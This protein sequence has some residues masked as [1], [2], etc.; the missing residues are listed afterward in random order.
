VKKEPWH[1]AG[2]SGT[3]PPHQ[4]GRPGTVHV[5]LLLVAF[6]ALIPFGAPARGASS[7]DITALVPLLSHPEGWY[8]HDILLE[9]DPGH[10]QAEIL[11]TLDGSTP[12][13]ENGTEYTQPIHLSAR[14]PGVT[15]LRARLASP[16]GELGPTLNASYWLGVQAELPMVSLIADP[17][18]LWGPEGGIHAHPLNRGRAWERPVYV[19]Y[20]E[21]KEVAFQVPAG[22]RIHG[23]STRTISKKSYRLYFRQEYGLNRLDYSLFEG[24]EG[25]GQGDWDSEKR[26]VL[27]DGGQDFAFPGYGANWT[28]IRTPLIND[29][30]HQLQVHSTSSRPVLLF[31]NGVPQGIYHIR[32]YIDDWFFAD[33]YGVDLTVDE[34]AD[35]H[36]E[37]FSEFLATQDVADSDNYLYLQSQ[38]DLSNLIDYYLLQIY[39]ANSDWLYTNV[40]RFLPQTHGGRWQWILW[41]VDYGFGL[42]PWGSYDYNMMDYIFYADRPGLEVEARPLRRLLDNPEFRDQFLGRAADLLNTVFSP[43][44]VV[45]RIDRLAAQLRPD[46]QY[47]LSLW[48]SPGD[49]EASV[50]Y[51]RE[52]ALK[53]PDAVREH[54]VQHFNLGGTAELAFSPPAEGKGRVAVN[55]MM[56]PDEPWQGVYFQGTVVRVTA[57]PEPGYCFA[58]WLPAELPQTPVITLSVS[59]PQTFAPRFQRDCDRQPQPGDVIITQL[60]V[61][62]R[63]AIEGDWLELRVARPGG[64]DLRGWRITDNDTKTSTDEGSLILSHDAVFSHVPF[65]TVILIVA[66][67]TAANDVRFPHDDLSTWPL[68]E[69]VLYR[70]NDHLDSDTDPWFELAENDNLVLLAPGPTP[71]F[72]D[73]RGI[74]FASVG[75]YNRSAVTP[76]S[77]G[78]LSHGVRAGV[79]EIYP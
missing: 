19:T 49:W 37:R 13:Q 33:K 3:S 28:L 79:P 15:V 24:L 27:H 68:G 77:F 12:L 2:A 59:G 35:E 41:D 11:Y 65:G 30:A 18:D 22:L 69:M 62:A 34:A 21:R 70:G 74:A 47:E 71:S 66:T 36:W 45:T 60:G 25:S 38:V 7:Q 44:S 39:V 31:L 61:D 56:V 10:P 14:A 16:D 58:G 46:I 43:E 9:M 54:L 75:V 20:L 51:L 42:A 6:L 48:S 50:A 17:A 76:A 1:L 78:I 5:W 67:E 4:D 8:D 55:G 29:L 72:Q 63:D 26:L 64:A 52:F 53:R 32:H 40:K 57:V 23:N 73:D